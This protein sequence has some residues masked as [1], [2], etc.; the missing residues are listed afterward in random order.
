M[1][2][3]LYP[4]FVR[5][6]YGNTTGSHVAT[7]PVIPVESAGVWKIENAVGSPVVVAD[8]MDAYADVIVPILPNAATVTGWE[9]WVIEALN[10]D[11]V[12]VSAGDLAVSGTG[13]ATTFMASQVVLSFR[14]FLG[15]TGRVTILDSSTA[16]NQKFLPSA[17]GGSTALV[18]IRDYLISDACVVRGRDGSRP[19][20]GLPARSKTNDAL[21]KKYN[22]A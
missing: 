18:G 15:G 16:P 20:A 21:R 10:T 9:L 19:I 2:N 17:Y 5:F 3:S 22:F 7:I 14:T 6:L 4:G 8:A 12:F 13:G 11:P 1:A